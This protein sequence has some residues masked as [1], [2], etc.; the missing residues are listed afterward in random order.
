MERKKVCY[1]KG[2]DNKIAFVFSC[3]GQ[4]EF[5]NNKVVFGKTGDNLDIF[6]QELSLKNIIVPKKYEDRYDFR[7]TNSHNQVYFKGYLNK[8]TQPNNKEINSENN[9]LRLFNE[10]SDI[11]D[12]IIVFGQKAKYALSCLEKNGYSLKARVH[13]VRHL[14]LQS[15]NQIKLEKE[16]SKDQ[17]TMQRIKII[18]EDLS[19]KIKQ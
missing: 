10:L 12:L 9:L 17:R 5:K 11:E 8:Q 3:P 13:Y 14:G 16:V 6:I 2:K 19:E 4:E 1:N 15:L 18:V 7:I